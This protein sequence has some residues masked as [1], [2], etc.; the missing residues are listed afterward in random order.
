MYKR[1]E[2][3][4]ITIKGQ[5]AIAQQILIENEF[6]WNGDR[7]QNYT[8]TSDELSK[9]LSNNTSFKNVD[10]EDIKIIVDQ[11]INLR[12]EKKR[13]QEELE[14]RIQEQKK[15]Y[16]KVMVQNYLRTIGKEQ[17]W[18]LAK[19]TIKNT[20]EFR[21]LND[22]NTGKLIFEEVQKFI[23]D[24]LATVTGATINQKKRNLEPSVKLDY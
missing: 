17:S 1:Q 21:E 6:Q 18:D 14:H 24:G 20:P 2:E 16:F 12:K 4:S 23:K 8:T 7:D 22:E 11:L 13:E 3:K 10:E 5:R 15:H 19:E 9:I